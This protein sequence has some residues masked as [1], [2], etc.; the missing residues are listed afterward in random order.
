MSPLEHMLEGGQD[1]HDDLHRVLQ[2]QLVDADKITGN[3]LVSGQICVSEQ[4]V[5][6]QESKHAAQ[7]FLLRISSEN[8]ALKLFSAL[9]YSPFANDLR[10]SYS[11]IRF[12]ERTTLAIISYTLIMMSDIIPSYRSS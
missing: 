4:I 12:F 8:P 9:D 11:L 2:R 10:Q 7:R 3:G 5:S 6:P 1:R